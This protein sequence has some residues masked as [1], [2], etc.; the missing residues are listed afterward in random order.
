M[1]KGN[2]SRDTV[3]SEIFARTLFSRNFA[4]SKF[5]KN[6]TLEKWQNHSVI[7]KS[8]LSREFFTSLICILMLFAKI[9]FSRKFPNLQYEHF[10]FPIWCPGS[11]YRFLIFVFFLTFFNLEFATYYNDSFVKIR[12]SHRCFLVIL[13]QATSATAY[14]SI[15]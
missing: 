14:R 13:L 3:N 9:N 4:C 2:W 12:K 7:G 8:C 5:R 15:N 10:H 11:G 6:K 1:W